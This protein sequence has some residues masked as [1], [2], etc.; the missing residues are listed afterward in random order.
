[1][2]SG[3]DLPLPIGDDLRRAAPPGTRV[4]LAL[5][6]GVD[7]A[8]SLAV[9]RALGCEVLAVTF[10]NFCHADQ[11]AADEKACCSLDAIAD[12]RDLAARHGARHWVHD[13]SARFRQRVIDPFVQEYAAARTPNPCL[14]CNA[15]VRFPALVHLARQQDCQLVATGHYARVVRRAD[16][17]A[18][19]HRGRD[20]QKDQSYFLGQV[21]PA[22][23]P[24]VVFPVGDATKPQVRAAAAAL[25][26]PAAT[27]AESQEICFLP[28]GDRG[29]LFAGAQAG[30]AGPIL[31]GAGRVLGEHRG[32]E[33]YTVGQ[34]RGLGIAHPEPLY[35]LALD[36][37]RNA[38]VV[39]PR[40]QLAVWRL[41]CDRFQAAVPELPD[42]GPDGLAPVIARVRH[43]HAGARVRRWARDGDRLQVELAEPVHGAAPGQGLILYQD[44]RV[45]GGGRLLAAA[46]GDPTD[47]HDRAAGE[48]GGR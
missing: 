16:G 4:L 7:S 46:D 10:K 40:P 14:A 44:D 6:G 48:Q 38:L 43:R 45:L 2:L 1:M 41:A 37:D 31:D 5:S 3:M 30:R 24:H 23:W 29:V 12:A 33:H 42:A 34:R 39:G 47:R 13:V 11:D 36:P 8:V 22:I 28:G 9:L 27:R 20:P 17:A 32:L 26:L 21:P 35:V 25:G 15:G 19:L 18:E